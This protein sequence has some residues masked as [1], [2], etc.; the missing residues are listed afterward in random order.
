MT[1]P[2]VPAESAQTPRFREAYEALIEEIRRV[3]NE[4]LIAIN[5]DIPTAVTTA[6]GA[7]PEIRALR[8]LIVAG[9]PQFDIARFDK[10]EGYTLAVGHAHALYLAASEPSESIEKLAQAGVSL[11][12]V[13]LADASALAQR[14]LPDG[15]RLKGSRG[16]TAT[17]PASTCSRWRCAR[18]SKVSSKTALQLSEL[19]QAGGYADRLLTAGIVS[20]GRPSWRSPPR[21]GSV[22]LRC[23][24]RPTTM[25]PC[26]DLLRWDE[27]E[28]T[29]LRRRSMAAERVGARAP[30]R[31]RRPS[32]PQPV[33]TSSAEPAPT[34][35]ANGKNRPVGVGLRRRTLRGR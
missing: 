26:G 14:R 32:P 2:I 8:P 23:S 33:P 11:R 7:L 19:D 3:P 5:I 9:M 18:L 29:R 16:S 10:L 34:A 27:D 35:G 1:Q 30:I 20:R 25:P 21:T 17:Q 4:E 28:M 15:Q 6:L 13:L 31:R 24:Y 22:R 12:E